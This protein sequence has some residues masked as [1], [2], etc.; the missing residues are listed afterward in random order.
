MAISKSEK[1]LHGKQRVLV[2][3]FARLHM[4]FLDLNGQSG[5]R[6]GS[7]GLGL[8]APDTLIELAIGPHVF[9]QQEEPYVLKSKQAILTYAN[10]EA[11][12][13]IFVHRAIPRHS[14]LGSGTQM[15]LAIGEGINRLFNLE[16]T[17]DE[18]AHVTGRGNRSGI[19]IGTFAKGGLVLDAGRG[20]QTVV[21]PIITQQDFPKDWCVLLIFDRQHVGVHGQAEL[22]AF[23]NL[24]DAD[25][26]QTQV[27]CHQVLMQA[28]PALKERNL[29]AFGQAI[30]LLQAYTGDYFASVQGGRY[31]SE[32]VSQ[33]LHYLSEQGVLCVGQTSWGPTGFAVFESKAVAEQ[34]LTR[35]KSTF[36]APS[37]SWLLCEASPVGASVKIAD[38]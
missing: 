1:Q 23:A 24:E 37:L 35:L 30:A 16:L 11:D 33:A 27:V 17:L 4:G 22:N 10:I 8:T 3:A 13:S 28:L 21:P 36:T 31:A 7:V 12:V 25:L 9:E 18:I 15:A 32:L 29:H 34:Y 20:A 5:R 2:N 6:F 38:C 26:Q 14:G 19:G